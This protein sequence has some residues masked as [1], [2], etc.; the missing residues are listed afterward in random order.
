[1]N[2]SSLFEKTG[3]L[4]AVIA[5]MGCAMCFPSL[6]SIGAL[7]GLGFL[8]RYEGLFI[9]TLLPVFA[10]ITLL[11]NLYSG[12]LH[13]RWLRMLWGIAGPLM[14]LTTLYLFWSEYWSTYLFYAGL[15]LMV[16]VSIWDIVSPS[17]K[18]CKIKITQ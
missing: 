8:A 15:V 13:R 14:I 10:A 5:T 17:G 1:M 16:L 6:A 2:I 18:L 11:A 7:L 9:N 3:S 12:F 4:G